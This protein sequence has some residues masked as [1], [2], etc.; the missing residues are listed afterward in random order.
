LRPEFIGVDDVWQ[1]TEMVRR[2]THGDGV[3]NRIPGIGSQ[4]SGTTQTQVASQWTS[5]TYLERTIAAQC[6][7]FSQT[8]YPRGCGHIGIGVEV[9]TL[10]QIRGAVS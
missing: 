9:L 4:H 6:P 5:G 7:Y 3:V 10:Q 2:N 8:Q 1:K